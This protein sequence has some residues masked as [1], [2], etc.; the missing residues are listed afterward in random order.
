MYKGD[1]QEDYEAAIGTLR[2]GA[3]LPL[4][5]DDTQADFNAYE[6]IVGKLQTDYERV[7]GNGENPSAGFAIV[8]D[9]AFYPPN[10]RGSAQ[11]EYLTA[12]ADVDRGYRH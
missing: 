10:Y 5:A 6:G 11:I 1:A 2:E 3:D 7:A 8:E 12:I 4:L 9:D